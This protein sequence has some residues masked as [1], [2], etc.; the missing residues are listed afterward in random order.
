V[1]NSSYR[2]GRWWGMVGMWLLV[3]LALHAP[4]KLWAH[5]HLV[6]ADPAPGALL[7][8]AP[9]EIRLTFGEPN[10]PWSRILLFAPGFR[11]IP[12]VVTRVNPD[13]PEQLIARLPPLAPDTYTVQWIAVATDKHTMRGSYTFG[14]QPQGKGYL[15]LSVAATL[16]IWA[17]LLVGSPWRKK[18]GQRMARP[19]NF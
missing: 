2:Q 11:S 9:T 16:A 10:D 13:A 7:T 15:W 1:N 8:T 12:G 14:V 19:V 6:A 18:L 17:L 4:A 5:T 3:L